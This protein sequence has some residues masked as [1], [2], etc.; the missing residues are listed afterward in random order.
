MDSEVRAF[1]SDRELS[2]SALVAWN[3]QEFELS[4]QCLADEVKIGD[5]YLRLLLEMDDSDDSPIRKS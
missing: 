2:G 4:Y 3:H 1:Q 5:Y